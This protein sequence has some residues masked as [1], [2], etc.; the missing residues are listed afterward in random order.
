MAILLN[1]VLWAIAVVL[2]VYEVGL[3]QAYPAGDDESQ[4]GDRRMQ[5][6]AAVVEYPALGDPTKEDPQLVIGANCERYIRFMRQARDQSADIIVFPEC[7]LTSMNLPPTREQLRKV[8]TPIPE[9][10][11]NPCDDDTAAQVLRNLSCATREA[12]MYTVIN[13]AEIEEC[14]NRTGCPD[15]GA[16]FYNTDVAFDRNGTI[17]A[18]YRKYNLFVEPGFNVTEM[19]EAVTFDT[20]WGGRVGLLTCQDFLYQEPARTLVEDLHVT[21][22]AYPVAWF[23]E[24]PFLVATSVQA[25]WSAARR[26]SVLASGLHRPRAG[27]AGS[28]VYQAGGRPLVAALPTA[29]NVGAGQ[30]LIA[31]VP[32][33]RAPPLETRPT[34]APP[35]PLPVRASHIHVKSS[36]AGDLLLYQDYLAPYHAVELL[37]GA[38]HAVRICHAG[39]ASVGAATFCCDVDAEIDLST[40]PPSS[41]LPY[42]YMA[43]IFSGVR[44]F[45][46]VKTAGIK[47][48]GIMA[49]GGET[50]A[51][52]EMCGL[53]NTSL[54]AATATL[55]R[56]IVA[57]NLTASTTFHLPISLTGEL[58]PVAADKLRY[59]ADWH[60]ASVQIESPVTDLLV[61]ALWARDTT[62]DGDQPVGASATAA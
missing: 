48:C 37:P 5:Y 22:I 57:A 26:V 23:N 56:A 52:G 1:V 42:R 49:C 14:A 59:N 40:P 13:I 34:A 32:I 44:N 15:D 7:G 43:G 10:Q 61:L 31:P 35:A 18:K 50:D 9:L 3:I 19:P 2:I 45:G 62:L 46:G 30:L 11:N 33:T 55:H 21:D 38:K 12:R 8:L 51:G 36:E 28:G 54:S 16:L 47:V 20:D 29:D 53:W 17:V 6:V 25:G 41:L 39:D 4:G 58:L 60:G 27:N 24:L